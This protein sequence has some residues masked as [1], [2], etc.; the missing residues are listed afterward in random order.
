MPHLIRSVEERAYLA[1]VLDG[2]GTFIIRRGRDATHGYKFQAVVRVT[3]T[4]WELIAWL[5]ATFGGNVV[6]ERDRR[7]NRKPCW[8][9]SLDGGTLV[10]PVVQQVLPY[11]RVK[12]RQAEVVLEFYKVR[13]PFGKRVSYGEWARRAALREDLCLLNRKGIA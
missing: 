1:G 10:V 7:P 6:R 9:W 3:N 12:R 2:E 11:L 5:H 4:S 8:L 13:N